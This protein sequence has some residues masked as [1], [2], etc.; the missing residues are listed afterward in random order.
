MLFHAFSAIYS[1]IMAQNLLASDMFTPQ[2]TAK[3]QRRRRN[4][5]AAV[6]AATSEEEQAVSTVA[7]GPLRPKE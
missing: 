5:A 2:T 3:S 1:H 4:V 6:S 7:E